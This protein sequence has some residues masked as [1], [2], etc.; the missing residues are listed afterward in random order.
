[1]MTILKEMNEL[2]WVDV[3]ALDDVT[4][5]TGVG[6]LIEHQ[7]SFPTFHNIATSWC[8]LHYR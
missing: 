6:A 3:C 4:P 1:M 7:L 5:N 2:N 8:I